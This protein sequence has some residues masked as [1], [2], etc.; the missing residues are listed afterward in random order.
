MKK[1]YIIG[2][3][4]AEYKTLLA[5]VEKLS[6]DAKLIFVGDLISRGSQGKEVVSV[7]YI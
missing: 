1:H 6:K 7:G 5:L 3:I 2:D 4:H